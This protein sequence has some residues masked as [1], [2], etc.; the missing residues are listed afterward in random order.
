MQKEEMIIVPFIIRTSYFHS[1]A[2]AQFAEIAAD[3]KHRGARCLSLAIFS[4][5]SA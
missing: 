3:M 4:F 1:A 5:A 2:L